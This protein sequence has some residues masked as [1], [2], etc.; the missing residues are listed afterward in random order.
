MTRC[1]RMVVRQSSKPGLSD[2]PLKRVFRSP[3]SA[4]VR[5]HPCLL[6]QFGHRSVEIAADLRPELW[7]DLGGRWAGNL[8]AMSHLSATLD[9]RQRMPEQQF[10]VAERGLVGIRH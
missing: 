5:Q 10:R 2:G 4:T 9:R 3:R 6:E 7:S 1:Q 8:E